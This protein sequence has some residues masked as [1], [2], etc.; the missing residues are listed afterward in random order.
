MKKFIIFFTCGIIL[1]LFISACGQEKQPETLT[2]LPTPEQMKEYNE[3]H[4][5][6]E[7]I[8]Y[9]KQV[10][11]MI[12]EMSDD[13]IYSAI[14]DSFNEWAENQKLLELDSITIDFSNTLRINESHNQKWFKQVAVTAGVYYDPSKID[15]N[16]AE[17]V[18]K[19]FEDVTSALQGTTVGQYKIAKIEL[20]FYG[21]ESN[22]ARRNE[23]I[24]DDLPNGGDFSEL[25]DSVDWQPKGE[26]RAQ[27]IAYDFAQALNLEEFKDDTL[28]TQTG[29]IRMAGLALSRF[30]IKKE[31]NEL[32]IEMAVYAEKEDQGAFNSSLEG[33]SRALYDSIIS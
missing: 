15:G 23:R 16:E 26:K 21:P 32:Y 2:E 8:A 4:G 19:V 31:T 29:E 5:E 7:R 1:L 24:M 10:V 27:T 17:L 25:Y 13:E 3:K 6:E 14:E 28:Y 12:A 33:R 9:S 30:G 20:A 22:G 11:T 18:D